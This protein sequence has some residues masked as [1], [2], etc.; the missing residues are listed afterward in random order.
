MSLSF[1]SQVL[2]LLFIVSHSTSATLLDL[3]PGGIWETRA[4]EMPSLIGVTSGGSPTTFISPGWIRRYE[5]P[6]VAASA[7]ITAWSKSRKL[8]R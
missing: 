8:V 1:A 5:S 4:A 6:L 7:L 2:P 3:A